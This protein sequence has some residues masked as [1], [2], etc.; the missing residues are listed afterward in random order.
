M[1][2]NIPAQA[3][4]ANSPALKAQA[5]S[6]LTSLFSQ[7]NMKI[8]ATHGEDSSNYHLNFPDLGK[9]FVFSQDSGDFLGVI[10]YVEPRTERSMGGSMGDVNS[11]TGLPTQKLP[12][13]PKGAILMSSSRQGG[14]DENE[15]L[16]SLF[17]RF[18]F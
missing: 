5:I 14:I 7:L 18:G 12:T 13:L 9:T 3:I 2:E 4:A 8:T 6:L 11:F 17:S 15:I 1:Q 10:N 16:R